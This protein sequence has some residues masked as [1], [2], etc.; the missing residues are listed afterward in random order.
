M[1]NRVD[2]YPD[3]ET[4]NTDEVVTTQPIS[5]TW[6]PQ[7]IIIESSKTEES[8]KIVEE[9]DIP[10]AGETIDEE[11]V[12]TNEFESTGLPDYYE[13]VDVAESDYGCFR[14]CCVDC[15]SEATFC[16]THGIWEAIVDSLCDCLCDCLGD[17]LDDCSC[18]CED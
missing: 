6:T 14:D 12:S 1:S 9:E 4:E 13:E 3:I 10:V 16:E 8:E 18:E 5:E 11:I 15:A 17:C 2:P 7:K